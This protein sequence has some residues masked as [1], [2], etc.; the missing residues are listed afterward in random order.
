MTVMTLR[1]DSKG[2]LGL[3]KAARDVLGLVADA[4]VT[5]TLED[6][7]AVIESTASVQE[8][9]WSKALRV[10]GEHNS[11]ETARHE[12]NALA[13]RERIGDSPADQVGNALLEELGLL[14]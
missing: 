2:R 6:G 7:R 8:R 1:I 14:Q 10:H 11:T 9:V 4:D 3:P 13:A 12:A 5:V